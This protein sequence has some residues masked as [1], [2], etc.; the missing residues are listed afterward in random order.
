[1]L[2]RSIASQARSRNRL[3]VAAGKRAEPRR[4]VKS[5]REPIPGS[6][7]EGIRAAEAG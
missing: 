5:K 1:M 2:Q 6:S 3:H 4:V 7:L